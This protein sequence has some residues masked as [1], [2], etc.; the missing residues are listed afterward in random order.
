MS[1]NQAEHHYPLLIYLQK[2]ERCRM[3]S[4]Y[5]RP[6]VLSKEYASPHV[7]LLQDID[8][9]VS[10]ALAVL[11]TQGDMSKENRNTIR[12]RWKQDN[13]AYNSSKN[14]LQYPTVD[15]NGKPF[16]RSYANAWKDYRCGHVVSKYAARI[17]QR[18][19]ASHLADSLEAAEDD[20]GEPSKR[21]R[22]PVDTSWIN[23]T[24]VHDILGHTKSSE[25]SN[26]GSEAQSKISK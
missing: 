25:R 11:E 12:L 16:Q 22:P 23:L 14:S 20:E 13:F 5:L 18:F 8:I 17:I 24:A 10:D 26:L 21:E 4:A 1:H 19:A 15:S 9:L 6:W 2:E 3:F 7:P